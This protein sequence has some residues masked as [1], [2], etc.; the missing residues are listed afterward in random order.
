M[1]IYIVMN[2]YSLPTRIIIK[3]TSPKRSNNIL[4]KF[5]M[6]IFHLNKVLNVSQSLIVLRDPS[7]IKDDGKKARRWYEYHRHQRNSNCLS[8][9]ISRWLLP[10]GCCGPARL[11]L[12]YL[13]QHCLPELHS[14]SSPS[15]SSLHRTFCLT[16]WLGT[17]RSWQTLQNQISLWRN[18][19][20]MKLS[21]SL[22]I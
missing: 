19:Q 16:S 15:V 1:Y 12:V 22:E 14:I 10:G 5:Q 7:N 6:K 4:Y 8:L 3:Q 18:A 13:S 9:R 20:L 21:N 2:K 11:L 17:S